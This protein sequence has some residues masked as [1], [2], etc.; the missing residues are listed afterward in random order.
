MQEAMFRERAGGGLAGMPDLEKLMDWIDANGIA[1][2]N[3][4]PFEPQPKVIFGRFVNFW[5]KMHTGR[6]Q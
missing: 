5:R 1:K 6:L 4:M 2:V 3:A